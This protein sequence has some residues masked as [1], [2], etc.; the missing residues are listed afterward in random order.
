MSF[1]VSLFIYNTSII[2]HQIIFVSFVT[3]SKL[4]YMISF[5]NFLFCLLRLA[6]IIFNGK[7]SRKLTLEPCLLNSSHR[8]TV[9]TLTILTWLAERCKKLNHYMSFICP[10]VRTWVNL[11]IEKYCSYSSFSSPWIFIYEEILNQDEAIPKIKA[12]TTQFD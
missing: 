6:T 1:F 8:T 3:S 9:Y 4:K 10:P 2:C 11:W 7:V 12:L 5:S